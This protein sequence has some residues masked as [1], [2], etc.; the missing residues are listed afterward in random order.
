M[1]VFALGNNEPLPE[2]LPEQLKSIL[3]D[4]RARAGY[5]DHG[6]QIDDCKDCLDGLSG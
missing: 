1:N 4:G 2:H 5:C 6:R 3:R